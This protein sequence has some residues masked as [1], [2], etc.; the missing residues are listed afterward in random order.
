M[1]LENITI[2]A[3]FIRLPKRVTWSQ[4]SNLL[5]PPALWVTNSMYLF[6]SR[7]SHGGGRLPK[8]KLLNVI[9]IVLNKCY[10]SLSNDQKSKD[11]ESTCRH[12]TVHRIG[13]SEISFP[14]QVIKYFG[15]VHKWPVFNGNVITK[16]M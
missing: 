5:Y 14:V 3:Y 4:N 7:P 9:Q 12:S 2:E 16:T 13:H 1:S 11:G 15:L 6:G 8:E 10:I